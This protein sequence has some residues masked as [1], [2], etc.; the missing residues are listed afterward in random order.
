MSAPRKPL[1][2]NHYAEAERRLSGASHRTSDRPDADF[3]N[4]HT[5]LVLSLQA[6]AHAALASLPD[7]MVAAQ[8]SVK[9]YRERLETVLRVVAGLVSEMAVSHVPETRKWARILARELD[10]EAENIDDRVAQFA[11]Q[12]GV[13]EGLFDYRGVRYDLRQQYVDARGK[14]WEHTGAW[15]P[16]RAPVMGRPDKSNS[17]KPSR[18]L[19]LRDLVNE[20][21]PLLKLSDARRDRAPEVEPPF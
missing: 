16:D 8:E 2:V 14:R 7:Q 15:T 10:R 17:E 18:Q 13:G 3:V 4:P 19:S 9:E 6:N 1:H 20:R 12:R 5:A 21:G 11:D